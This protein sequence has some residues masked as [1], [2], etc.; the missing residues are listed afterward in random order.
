[1]LLRAILAFLLMPGVVAVL[2]PLMM[3]PWDRVDSHASALPVLG[4]GT[5]AL[6]WC[7][8]L[9][10]A[11]Y[12]G[13]ARSGS[14]RWLWPLRFTARDPGRRALPWRAH[15]MTPGR[16]TGNGCAAGCKAIR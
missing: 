3:V 14:T 2:V 4:P 8:L 10:W 15:P 5:V 12:S 13:C 7:V 1:M 6:L 9:G 11:C 16:T